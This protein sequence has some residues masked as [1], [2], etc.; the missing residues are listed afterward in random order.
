MRHPTDFPEG[1]RPIGF[2]TLDSTNSE[3]IRLLKSGKA[4]EDT[5]IIADQQTGGRGRRNASWI[6]PLGNLYMT[7]VTN[8]QRRSTAGQLSFVSALALY[9]GVIEFGC[10]EDHLHIK[11]PNDIIFLK[12]KLAGILVESAF[13]H[14]VVG[15]GVN[16]IRPRGELQKI[17]VGLNE[18][19]LDISP[20]ELA[21]Q[22]AHSFRKWHRMWQ[23]K[24]FNV[25]REAWLTRT[26]G[27]GKEIKV[28]FPKGGIETGIFE[29][30]DSDG[31]LLLRKTDGHQA[32]VSA[33]EIFLL[34]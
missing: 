18:A 5:I 34:D 1:M 29:G 2:E 20:I 7:I 33:A 23:S 10:S 31:C 15:I 14:Y 12:K 6:S 26:N 22:I 24:G 16:I 19:G 8:V 21:C 30:I 32:L 25:I 27:V 17:A 28:R 9:D 3:A 11:W 13:Q 4:F